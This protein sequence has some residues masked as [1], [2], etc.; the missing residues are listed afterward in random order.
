MVRFSI[1][2]LSLSASTPIIGPPKIISFAS[3]DAPPANSSTSLIEV[4]IGT[5]IFLGSLTAVP[6]TV[7]RFETRGIPV[8]IKR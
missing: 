3:S 5:I 8:L 2:P 6:S 4:P 7:I 1:T